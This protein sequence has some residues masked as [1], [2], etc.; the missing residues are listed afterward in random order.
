MSKLFML[1]SIV[2]AIIGLLLSIVIPLP[3]ILAIIGGIAGFLYFRKDPFK[4]SK[5]ILD[6]LKS[7][8]PAQEHHELHE[9]WGAGSTPAEPI[10]QQ[11]KISS[12][13]IQPSRKKV[14]TY[15][16]KVA[17]VTYKCKLDSSY[18]RQEILEFLNDG[19]KLDIKPYQYR[20]KSAY[21]LIDPGSGLDI[22]NIPAWA[23]E[24]IAEKY[25]GKELEAYTKEVDSFIP[26]DNDGEDDDDRDYDDVKEVYYCKATVFVLAD[27]E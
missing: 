12:L 6:S 20:G 19:L 27:T 24:E 4:K 5:E 26:D 14:K 11:Q 7:T 2:L 18:T 17:G 21:L 3:G 25:P 1:L 22:G 16:I 8:E 23:A 13:P 10:P 9:M 15:Q